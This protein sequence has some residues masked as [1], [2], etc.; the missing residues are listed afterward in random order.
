MRNTL[1]RLLAHPLTLG[2]ALVTLGA[3]TA[4]AGDLN[5]ASYDASGV[6]DSRGQS[7]TGFVRFQTDGNQF[8]AGFN[9][10]MGTTYRFAGEYEEIDLFVISFWTF[11]GSDNQLRGGPTPEATGSGIRLFF[12]LLTFGSLEDEN[13]VV[14]SFSGL[15]DEVVFA[16]PPEPVVHAGP[17]A[18]CERAAWLRRRALAPE[19]A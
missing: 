8:R 14:Y 9:P 17:F 15:F 10:E 11:E 18:A 1:R 13:G 3:G 16:S 6:R 5:Y 2:L 7:I 19:R 4:R 12:G